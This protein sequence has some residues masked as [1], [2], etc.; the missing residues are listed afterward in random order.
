MEYH[1]F[2]FLFIY[3]N[4]NLFAKRIIKIFIFIIFI[5]IIYTNF[6]INFYKKKNIIKNKF[7]S[8]KKKKTLQVCL[9]I[10]GKE[11]NIYAKEYIKN[12]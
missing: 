4:S 11:E 5:L 6:M 9:C 7:N 10:M 12:V 8:T 3:N 2:K 1:I